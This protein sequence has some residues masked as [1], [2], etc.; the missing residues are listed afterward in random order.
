VDMKAQLFD[1]LEVMRS[2]L[3]GKVLLIVFRAVGLVGQKKVDFRGASGQ[4]GL[5]S[6]LLNPQLGLRDI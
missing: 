2:L 3:M 6:V 4:Q 1:A 5:T